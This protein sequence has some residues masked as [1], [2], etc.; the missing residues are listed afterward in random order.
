[1]A[2]LE[3]TQSGV[4]HPVLQYPLPLKGRVVNL[5]INAQSIEGRVTSAR[6]RTY[7]YFPYGG[8]EFYVA[9]ELTEDPVEFTLPDN[10]TPRQLKSR[11]DMYQA[12]KNQRAAKKLA[13]QEAG[14]A[15]TEEDKPARRSR[16]QKQQDQPGA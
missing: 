9:G 6:G 3:L 12:T 8:G 15:P 13:E 2:K 16:R 10:F 4:G 1:M 14:G 7:T 11:G 5:T